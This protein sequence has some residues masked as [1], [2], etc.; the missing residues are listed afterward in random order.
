MAISFEAAVDMLWLA[1]KDTL[2]LTAS[3]AHLR[4]LDHQH[5]RV[6]AATATS[7]WFPPLLFRLLQPEQLCCILPLQPNAPTVFSSLPAALLRAILLPMR[8]KVINPD[9]TLQLLDALEYSLDAS[10]GILAMISGC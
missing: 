5:S 7:L 1:V 9:A 4:Q 3:L 8:S 2:S 10:S 6:S